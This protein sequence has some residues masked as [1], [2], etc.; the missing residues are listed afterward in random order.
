MN[1]NRNPIAVA[2]SATMGAAGTAADAAD[3]AVVL[4]DIVYSTL[5]GTSGADLTASSGLLPLIRA[6]MPHAEPG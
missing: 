5:S 4:A 1:H 2:I 3:H 6:T